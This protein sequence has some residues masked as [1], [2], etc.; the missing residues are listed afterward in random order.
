MDSREIYLSGVIKPMA[1]PSQI[2]PEG[3]DPRPAY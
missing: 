1:P 2:I 3:Q